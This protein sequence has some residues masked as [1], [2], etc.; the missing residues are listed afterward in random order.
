MELN[1]AIVTYLETLVE[2]NPAVAG[3]ISILEQELG[4]RRDS[5]EDFSARS[6]FPT[7]LDSIFSA[8]VEKLS[9]EHP[10]NALAAAQADPKFAAF[11][12]AVTKK[13]FFKNCEEGSVEYLQRQAKLV[14]KFKEKSTPVAVDP[15]VKE[16]EAEAKKTLGNAAIVAKTYPEAI[17]HYTEALD[18]S[19]AGPNSHVYYSNRAAAHCHLADYKSAISDCEASLA[20]EPSYVKAVAR[21]GLANYF[22]ANYEASVAAYEKALQL[23]PN[24]KATADALNKAKTKLRKLTAPAGGGGAG[25]GMPDMASLAS[26]MGGGGGGGGGGAGGLGDMLKNPGM[27]D[28]AQK[29]MSNPDMMSKA[30]EMM[31]DPA[32]MQKAMSMMG[33]MGGGGGAGGMPDMSALASMMGGMGG[34]GGAPSAPGG[35]GKKEKFTGFGED[36]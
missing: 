29:M 4:V 23:E 6:F 21:L 12:D 20:L 17:A 15:A 27:M 11:V 33:G 28:M 2:E 35:T 13:G 26:M 30:Q 32:M 25:G 5:A 10:G 31:K 18:L 36:D 8:G 34:G 1:Y 14:K 16:A 7:G 3:A 9:G 22:E 24:N 19:P